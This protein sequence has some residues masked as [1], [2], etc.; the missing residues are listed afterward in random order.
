MERKHLFLTV[1]LLALFGL[2]SVTSTEAQVYKQRATNRQVNTL[3]RRVENRTDTFKRNMEV[4]LD[5][6]PVN[7]TNQEDRIADFIRDFETATD[8]LRRQFDSRQAVS[9]EVN[10]VLNRATYIDRFMRRHR[11]ASNVETEWT[12]LRGD[13]NTLAMYYGTTWNWNTI[14][15]PSNNSNSPAYAATRTQVKTLL[16]RIETRTDSFKAKVD[17]TRWNSSKR[18]DRITSY[19]EDFERA[20]DQLKNRF[21]AGSSTD[22]EVTD[23]LTR[24][25]YIDEVARRARFPYAAEA[26]WTRIRDDLNTLA[27]YYRVSW[28]W[29][30]PL[31][32]QT[33]GGSK[34]LDDRLTG[35][36][37]L[38]VSQSDNVDRVIDRSITG[39]TTAQR[40]RTRNNLEQRLRSPEM[41]A[42][43]KNGNQ[44]VIAS[45]LS[46]QITFNADGIARSETN[47]RGRTIRT[48][49]STTG[50]TLNISYEGDRVNDFYL[51]LMPIGNNQVRMTRRIYL[52]NRNEQITVTTV[53]DKIN[54]TAQWSMV[55]SSSNTAGNNSDNNYRDFYVPN[56]T[57]MTASLR[58]TI[59]TRISHEGDR[60][61]ME[62][63]SPNQYRGAVIEGRVAKVEKSGRVSGRANV[64]L[65]FETIRLPNGQTYRFAGL[66]DSV[67]TADGDEVSV[68]NEGA[69]RD[70]NQTTKTVTR[71]GI[72]AALGA[73]IGAIAGGGEGAAIGAAIGAGAGAGTVLIQGRDNVVLG[74]N[75]EFRLTASAPNNVGAN[76]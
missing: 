42:I 20:T 67:N 46:P 61:A 76:Y 66:I 37:R 12:R 21:E 35:T 62:V 15:T 50:D 16:D 7:N 36:Y 31:P 8:S 52:E 60:F 38:N 55:N 72:G 22:V 65:E 56:G 19:V 3:L 25:W 1:L 47:N 11:L 14:P 44:V 5:R 49:A 71:A 43:D 29:N 10:E 9:S 41:I 23:V 53:Y 32:S 64:S 33:A 13:L 74:P 40:D 51:T 59:D 2:G 26:D 24:A 45:S 34:K 39:G 17:R 18:D 4:A 70:D 30:Q 6:S 63:T 73:L 58:N 69:V 28:N 68:N 48:T 75:T 54:N 57:R 27:T